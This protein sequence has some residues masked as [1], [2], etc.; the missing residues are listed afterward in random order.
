MFRDKATTSPRSPRRRRN[1][2]RSIQLDG[3]LIA[4]GPVGERDLE[5]R[6]AA[7]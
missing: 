3:R 6:G 1:D 5:V 4:D 2:G 7:S